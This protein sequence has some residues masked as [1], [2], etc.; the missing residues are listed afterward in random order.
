M[1]I[2][3][4]KFGSGRQFKK[5]LAELMRGM[6]QTISIRGTLFDKVLEFY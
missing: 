3:L 4:L 1:K 6:Y 2:W 5:D